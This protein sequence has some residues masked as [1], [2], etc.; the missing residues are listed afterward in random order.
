MGRARLTFAAAVVLFVCCAEPVPAGSGTAG[1]GGLDGGGGMAGSNGGGYVPPAGGTGSGPSGEPG[2]ATNCTDF[3]AEPIFDSENGSAPPADAASYFGA[4]DD[5]TSPGPCVV[6]PEL[7]SDSRP[8]A[9]LPANWLRPRFRFLPPGNEDLWEIRLQADREAND[10]VAYT[11]RTT[12][13]VPRD[14]WEAVAG[15]VLDEPITVTIRGV[16]TA[17]GGTPSGTR[18]DFTIAPVLAGGKM[19]YW[20]TTSSEVAPDTSKL[21][22]FAVGDEGVIDALT[23]TQVGDRQILHEGGRDL[24]GQYSDPKGVGP[25]HVQCIGCHVA[26]PDGSATA[27]VD[28][29]PWNV[30]LASVEEETVGQ[31]PAYLSPGAE[32]LV[33]QPWL[34]VPTFSPSHW[35]PGERR[36]I[37][38]YSQRNPGSGG[39]GFTDSWTNPKTDDVLAWFDLETGATFSADPAQGDVAAQLNQQLASVFGTAFGTLA[40]EGETRSAATPDWSHDGTRIAYSS[41]THTQDGRLG[42]NNSEVD[43]HV[44]P[45]NDGRG[46]A[47]SPLS[48]ASQP[49]VAEYYPAFSADDAL[50]AFN[51]VAAIDTAMMYYRPD[52]EVYV[53][54]SEGGTATRLLANDPPACSGET[55]PGI[56]NSWPKWSPTVVSPA[57]GS[58]GAGKTYYWLIFSSARDYPGRFQLPRTQYSPPDT[59]SSQLYMAG[60]VVDDASGEIT[61]YPAV[62]LWNQDTATSNLTPAWDDFKIPDVPIE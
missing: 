41:A 29:W 52:A 32:M 28:H 55:S 15:N 8:G 10:L 46:G 42:D 11:T 14:I 4:A 19:V 56:I 26:T 25:G 45:Y 24:R 39:V 59:R 17:S 54:P 1:S 50:I 21:V 23:I 62:Y 18:G 12:W 61:T 16:N 43:I 40:L 53:I 49:G 31:R 37:T 30:V 58:P 13:A 47:V 60:V 48:G 20:A 44:V 2:C 57:P 9:L 33:N 6:E 51:R 5:F 22:G 35:A 36:M 38:S 7:S 3:P 27:F 34:G